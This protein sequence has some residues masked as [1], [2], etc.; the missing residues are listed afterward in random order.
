[1]AKGKAS[2]DAAESLELIELVAIKRLMVF[3]LLRSGVSQLEVAV[4]LDVNQSS[5]S[6]MFPGGLPKQNRKASD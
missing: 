2:S 3:Q 1:M 4:A 6:R 5:I